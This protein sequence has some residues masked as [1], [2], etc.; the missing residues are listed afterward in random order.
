MDQKTPKN[1]TVSQM[2]EEL[3]NN[4]VPAPVTE[5]PNKSNSPVLIGAIII[6]ILALGYYLITQSQVSPSQNALT[7]P[8]QQNITE[9]V[10]VLSP[11]DSVDS[12]SDSDNLDTIE[13]ELN[14]TII[15]V[16]DADYN[17]ITRD[18]NSL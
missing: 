5:N 12:L 7:T 8:T 15:E 16:E 4:K 2:E 13:A 9:T 14:A 17:T 3:I 6:V 18:I 11:S 1:I 10:P